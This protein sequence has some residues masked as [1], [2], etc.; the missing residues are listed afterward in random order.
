MGSFQHGFLKNKSVDTAVFEFVT[1][2]LSALERG[3]LACGLFIDLSR[4][5]DTIDHKLLLEKLFRYGIRGQAYLWFECYLRGRCQN[6]VLTDGLESARSE[7]L[8]I[9]IGVPQGS[10]LGP[11]MFIIFINDLPDTLTNDAHFKLI[12]YADDTNLL[13][14]ADSVAAL[15]ESGNNQFSAVSEWFL[16]N[17]LT[18]NREKTQCVVFRTSQSRSEVPDTFSFQNTVVTVAECSRMLGLYLDSNIDWHSHTDHLC[19]KLSSCCYALRVLGEHA[20]YEVLKTA[21]FGLF[22]SLLKYGIM[23]WGQS[24]FAEDVFKIQKRA[25]RILHRLKVRE[26]CRGIFRQ[27]NM[28]TVT[29]LYIH[30]CMMFLKKHPH[31]F[32]DCIPDHRY[33]TRVPL[34]YNYPIHRLTSTERGPLYSCIKIYNHL[35]VCLREDIARY[36]FKG[37]LFEYLCN[38]E[39]YS[40]A[41]F[42]SSRQSIHN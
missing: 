39:P 6:V 5:F 35:P 36:S 18:L 21:Y 13:I 24:S 34:R 42:F 26:S 10:I 30:G 38:M 23:F 25:V 28:L 14:E 15:V 8:D 4:A 22:H 11:L 2:V 33:E 17:G 16:L 29:A 12:N 31:Y 20:S 1:A 9:S 40:L 32:G 19:G 41:E 3:N 37:R 27:N 7:T